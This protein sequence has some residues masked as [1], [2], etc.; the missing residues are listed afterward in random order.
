M[1][2]ARRL[3]AIAALA[4]LA[5]GLP[6]CSTGADAV[7]QTSGSQNG[8][9]QVSGTTKFFEAGHRSAAPAINAPLLDGGSFNLAD[10]RGHVVVMNLWGSWCPDCRVEA[11]DLQSVYTQ[12]QKSGVVFVGIDTRD[13]PDGARSYMKAKGVTYPSINDPSGSVVLQFRDV[14]PSAIPST[15]VIDSQ[16]KIAA[17]HLG[18][19][20]ADELTSLIGK[21]SS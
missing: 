11:R 21:A 4:A 20:D 9:V 12:H 5:L 17:V 16:G 3:T 7:D 19:I 6:A 15:L 14:P 2:A 18:K 13:D 8:Y 1:N 10:Q